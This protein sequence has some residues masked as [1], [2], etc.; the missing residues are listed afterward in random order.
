METVVSNVMPTTPMGQRM[1]RL[2]NSLVAAVTKMGISV[3]GSRVLY[4]RGRTSGQWR[5]TPVNLLRHEGGSYLVAPRGQL[6]VVDFAPHQ[7]E[8]LR[9][10]HQHRRLGFSDDEMERWTKQAGLKPRPPAALPARTA[11]APSF[12]QWRHRPAALPDCGTYRPDRRTRW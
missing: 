1:G 11:P 2:F 5:T 8:F 6:L 7:L 3:Y 10:A 4:V 9:Q 12:V